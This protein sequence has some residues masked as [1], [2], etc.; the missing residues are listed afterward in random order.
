MK[1]LTQKAWGY[2]LD[3]LFPPLCVK[4]RV[5]LETDIEKQNLLC[6]SCF[7]GIPIYKTVS[8][9][10]KFVL[11]AVS[12]YENEALRNLLHAFKYSRFIAADVPIG[13]LIARYLNHVNIAGTLS[14]DTLVIPIPLHKNRLRQRG[15]NQADYI[16]KIIG[17]NLG[18]PIESNVLFR[19][20]NTPHQ[21]MLK[22]KK[23]RIESLRGSFSVSNNTNLRGADII[24][25]DDVYTSGA[26]MNEAIKTL[27]R[28]GV[29][30]VTCF[31]IAKAN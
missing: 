8:Y 29:K 25:V 20:K 15:F 28:A 6:D 12:S 22:N 5:Y 16:A 11:A 1:N 31:V 10:P 4:C 23:E 14:P 26:T 13:K 19:I 2:V 3:I 17:K 27:K 7:H 9:S 21:T 18:L 24:L 30:N